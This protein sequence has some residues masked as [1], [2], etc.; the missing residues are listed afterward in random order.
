[1]TEEILHLKGLPAEAGFSAREFQ[2]FIRHAL[3]PG[4]LFGNQP[5]KF[6]GLLVTGFLPEDFCCERNNRKRIPIIVNDLA[7][8]LSDHRDAFLPQTLLHVFG[9]GFAEFF[10]NVRR[11]ADN[12]MGRGLGKYLF[13]VRVGYLGQHGI[14][15]CGGGGA[16]RL[17]V[18][19]P[20][21][22][23]IAVGFNKRDLEPFAGGVLAADFNL[24][25]H[26]DIQTVGRIALAEDKAS[27]FDLQHFGKLRQALGRPAV[28]KGEK[29]KLFQV[30]G[31]IP[32]FSTVSLETL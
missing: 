4:D 28:K 26:Q 6:D 8:H 30:H 23:E 31:S 29:F 12:G 15:D 17:S 3:H 20:E 10:N 21:L 2:K 16:A 24:A 19:H 5:G 9:I 14:F 25:V 13:E 7:H 27:F 22:S 18:Q 1:M 11:K 32:S